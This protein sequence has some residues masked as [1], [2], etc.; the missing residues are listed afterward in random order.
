YTT[1]LLRSIPRPGLDR[2]A[3]LPTIEG[4]VPSPLEL[5]RG[6]RF[7]PRCWKRKLL[8]EASQRRCL[9]ED[10]PLEAKA[11][12]GTAACHFPVTDGER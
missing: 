7:A 6:C 11:G 4:T 8:D 10:P 9:E 12:G 2:K 1:G 3:E 5:P